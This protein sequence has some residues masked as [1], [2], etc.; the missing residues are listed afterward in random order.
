VIANKAKASVSVA[1]PNTLALAQTARVAQMEERLSAN[2]EVAGSIPATGTKFSPTRSANCLRS[3]TSGLLQRQGCLDPLSFWTHLPEESK[4]QID[5]PQLPNRDGQGAFHGKN[6]VQRW[7]CQ[8]CGKRFSEPQQKPFGEDVR[9]PVEK[10]T[11]ILHC[12]VEGNSVR[13]TARL[14]DVEKRTVL[15]MLKLAGENCERLLADR[16]RNVA[17]QDVQCDEIWTFVQTKEGHKWPF[18]YDSQTVGDAY[19]FIALERTSKLVLAWHL[20]KRDTDNTTQFIRKLRSATAPEKF[21]LCTDAFGSYLPAISGALYDRV[22]YS[23]VVRVYSKQEEGRER[24]SP[25][26]FV[27]V[28]NPRSVAIRI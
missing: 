8:T 20:G 5:L 17:V 3:L 2:R 7:K 22:N 4:A 11:M 23:Q 9:L 10:V 14:C 15:T 26:E 6:Q 12:L 18:E 19:T 25:G 1:K 27:T 13:S 16:V 24:Y 21:E 28:E